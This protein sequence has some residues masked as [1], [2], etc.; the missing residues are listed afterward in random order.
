MNILQFMDTPELMNETFQGDSW[1]TWR[2]ILSATFALPMEKERLA[3]FSELSGSRK[4]PESRVRELWVVAGRRS[5]KTQTAGSIAVY[6]AT[7][8]AAISGLSDKLSVGERGVIA[9]LAV[10]RQQAKVALGYI[11]GMVED[12][13]VLSSMV[14]KKNTDGIDFN[15]RVS[16]EVHTNNFRA[17]RGR[18]LLAVLLDEVAFFRSDNS[19]SPDIETYRAA[20]P[21][22]ATTGGLLIGFSSPYSKRG[23]L[24]KKY[25]KHYG[26]DGDVL[27]VQGSTIDFNPTINRQ[28]ITEAL[29]D[30]PEAAQAE[31][32]G[33]F[34]NDVEAFI[35]RETIESLMRASPLELPFD[36]AYRYY[37]FTDPAGGGADE[38]TLAIGHI[39]KETLIVDVVRAEKGTPS[40]ITEEYAALLKVYGICEVKGDHYGGSWPAD[41]FRRHHI[42]YRKSELPK[43]GLYQNSLALINSGRVEL[44]PCDRL[45]NQFTGLERRTSRA[46]RDSIDHAPNGHD[47]RAN[48]VAGLI[49]S[50]AN[51]NIIPVNLKVTFAR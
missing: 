33:Q 50:T 7:V 18:T 35:R 21:G 20:V 13:P 9:L 32:L 12:S 38:F 14:T 34:R 10:D 41:E 6:L 19:A 17:I 40:N 51:S 3:L 42:D 24:Y 4:P 22:L 36:S 45:L 37:A 48:A 31:W 49:V 44:P 43:S 29:E 23:L 28:I 26:Q 25:R 46:G 39:E 30:D 2:A 15:N 16:I 5:A 27:V 8:G 47:D 11:T 1:E